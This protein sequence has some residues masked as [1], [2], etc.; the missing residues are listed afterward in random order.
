LENKKEDICKKVNRL[1]S[2]AE[3]FRQTKHHEFTEAEKFY[4]GE[5]WPQG[6]RR[7]YKNHV[8]RII[9]SV[10]PVMT[11]SRPDTDVIAIDEGKEF[12]AELLQ[13]AKDHVYRA[14]NLSLRD[15]MSIRAS[16]KI[17]TAYQYVDFDPDLC[18]GEGDVVVKNIP[19]RQVFPDPMASELDE[20]RYIGFKFPVDIEDVKRRFPKVDPEKLEKISP[21]KLMESSSS[22]PFGEDQFFLNYGNESDNADKYNSES[23]TTLEEMWLK[24]YS[25]VPID[26]EETQLEISKESVEIQQGINPDIH[27]YEDH[28]AHKAG[29]IE[30]MYIMAA[31]A[32]GVDASEITEKDIENLKQDPEIG[33]IFSIAQDHIEMHET[34]L[35]MGHDKAQK[36]KYDKN[37]RVVI[38]VG[39]EVLYDGNDPSEAGLYPIA[40]FYCYKE[41][42]CFYAT[43]E[44]KH[45]IPVQKSLN[46]MDWAEYSGLRLNGNSGWV[47]DE[48]SGVDETTLDNRQGIVVKKKQG[49]EV[50]RLQSGQVSP[51]FSAR[52]Q[53]DIESMQAV[54]GVNEATMGEA[55]TGDPS[56]VAIKKLQQQAI[57]RIRL[58]SRS[59]EEY[60][61]PKRD[62]LILSRIMKYYSTE[63]KLRI[64]DGEGQVSFV[65]FDPEAVK[66]L[67]YDIMLSPGTSAGLDKE[68]VITIF[69]ELY[70]GQVIDA[71]TLVDSIDIP[72]KSK[73]KKYLAENDQVQATLQQLQ[74]ENMALKQELGLPVE[75]I[76]E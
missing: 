22:D 48:N 32:L 57:G 36:P 24:D 50:R 2:E 67:K 71:K 52:K 35:E 61:I 65:N 53:D 59:L 46:E 66:N 76:Q 28:E 72:M 31:Q 49:T 43:G 12:E 6:I 55:P 47:V 9:E 60:T 44:A 70:Q 56:G 19:W 34:Y 62:K 27:K 1:F 63:R 23:L 4:R 51:Q 39:K 13:H 74:E 73:I 17:G 5:H 64:E 42:D 37:M 30:Q 7:P 68:A 8:F 20:C 14:Q 15:A 45:L 69:K 11:D 26:D 29:H 33:L 16:L 21:K 41:E 58:K 38:K 18:D 75:E 10:V 3:S 40:P 54:S 25:M